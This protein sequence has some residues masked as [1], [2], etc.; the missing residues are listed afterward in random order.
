MASF[1][2]FMQE[3]ED[4]LLS[5]AS[6]KG[7]VF[8]LWGILNNLLPSGELLDTIW[9]QKNPSRLRCVF[10]LL[11][12]LLLKKIYIVSLLDAGIFLKPMKYKPKLPVF[13]SKSTSFNVPLLRISRSTIKHKLST[14]QWTPNIKKR[15]HK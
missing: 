12:Q 7:V 14:Q 3:N 4:V 1:C 2:Y 5:E 13:C 9:R 15:S 8:K 11:F 10:T 6:H